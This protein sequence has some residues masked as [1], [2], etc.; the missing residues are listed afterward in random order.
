[1]KVSKHPFST[2][3]SSVWHQRLA[4]DPSSLQELLHYAD[5][6]KDNTWAKSAASAQAQLSI[7]RDSLADALLD[8]HGS[9]NPTKKTLANIEALRDS[10]TV[11]MVTGQQC[12]L[13]GGPSMIAH[14]AMSIIVQSKKLTKI[15]DRQ[16]VPVFW[17]AD[18]DHDLAEVLEG[19]AWGASLDEVNALSMEWPAMSQEQIIASSTMVGSLALP[20]SLRQTTEAWHMADSVRDT[21]S[22]AY[23][24]G[25]SLRDGMARWLSELFGHHGLVLFS[26]QHDAFHQASAS[27]LSRAVSEAESIG[28]ALSQSTEAVLASGGHQQASIDGT[29]LFHVNNTGQRVKWTQ[30]Q[31]QWCHAAMSKGESKDALLLA[32]YVRQHP[33]EVSPNVFMRLVLQSALLPVVGAALG[34]AELA[35]AGQSTKM[36]EWAGL[37]QPVW[38]P[39]YSLTLLDG[40]KQPWLDELGLQWTAFQQPLHELQTTWVD[41]L[42]PNELESALSQWET[43][44]EGQAGELAEQV[45]GL[46][47]TLEASVDASRARMVKELDRVRTKIRRAIR[48]RESVQMSRMERLATRLMP[49]GALQERTIATWSVLSHFGEHVFDQLMDSLEGQEPDGHFLIQFE[50]VS[51]LDNGRPHEGKDVIRRKALKERKAMDSEDYATYSKKLSNGLIKLLEKTKPARIATFLPKIDAHEPDIRPAIE[52]AWALGVE[53]MVPKWSPQSPEMTFLPISSWEDVA[54]DDQGYLQPHGHGENEYEEPDGGVHDELEVQIP[55][56]LWIPAVALDT[57]GGRI[58]YG[59][60]YFDRAI[61]AIHAIDSK[62]PKASKSVNNAASAFPQRWAVCFS[63]WVYTDPIPQEAHDQAVHRIITENGILE[64]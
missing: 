27:L 17:L 7:S 25:G 9:W 47:A 37:C 14:K 48:R 5:W 36:F 4:Q 40:G 50:G 39:R 60:G 59:K 1:M 33:E 51:P 31:G 22:R 2:L 45:K 57:Q 8:L 23:T 41:S 28:Q 43:L 18:E 24:E 30:D 38:M 10:K 13:F 34:P 42:H 26:R 58:G 62:D 32:E 54:Q 52:A 21:L 16:V 20:A 49:A 35:Y 56:V 44:L 46:D 15:L 19:H 12:N 63:S 55:D 64:V 6:T 3:G 29:V 53:V 61:H 11:V